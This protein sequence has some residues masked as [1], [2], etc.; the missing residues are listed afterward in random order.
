MKETLKTMDRITYEHLSHQIA[1][2]LYGTDEWKKAAVIGIT[3]SHFPEVDTWQIIRKGWEEGKKMVIP[4]CIPA[5]KEMMF[6][7]ISSFNQLESV[8]FGLF[9]PMEEETEAITRDAIDTLIVPGLA[10]DREG[11]RIGF[12]GGYYDRFLMDLKAKT[13][14]LAF[15][16]QIESS[17]PR[18]TY[19]IPVGKIITDQEIIIC[20]Q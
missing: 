9:E 3:V 6:R 14:S 13:I 16:K 12:G 4:K 7:S 20:R 1:K 18:E 5:S 2:S 8:Y 17:L 10:Y 15:Q 11:Y 19:D